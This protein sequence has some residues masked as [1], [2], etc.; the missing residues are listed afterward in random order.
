MLKQIYRT[1]EE[2]RLRFAP[3]P[4]TE[5][6]EMDVEPRG[7]RLGLTG[8]V[9]SSWVADELLDRLRSLDLPELVDRIER[10]PS[11]D[12]GDGPW[13]VVA[14]AAAPVLSGPIV[15][16]SPMSQLPMGHVVEVLRAH[17]RWLQCRS[18]DRN[19]GW[20][21]RGYLRRVS[22]DVAAKWGPG[23]S[24]V[25]MSLGCEVVGL[26]D[27]SSMRLPWGALFVREGLRAVLPNGLSGE[28]VGEVVDGR[29]LPSLFP[30]DGQAIVETARGWRGSPYLWGGTTPWGV[31]CSGLVQSIYRAHGVELPR[32]SD[33]QAEI[34]M[35]VDP[36]RNFSWL[37]PGD[38]LF[39]AEEPHRVSHVAISTGGSGIIHS[40]LGSGGV[41]ENDLLERRDY[42]RELR[43]WFVGAR[44]V[45]PTGS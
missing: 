2:V 44:R 37:R 42:E 20:I 28:L 34:G 10:L 32:D 43:S 35:E 13:G 21:H 8:A 41:V 30:C 7:R 15:S 14:A 27:G 19:I 1:I 26:E 5:V 4:R 18:S 33:Q 31:D 11:L 22:E 40:A 38:L 29:D 12:D 6:F 23:A 36:G 9:T 17:G 45:I 25:H 24:N 39:F 16:S 3:D